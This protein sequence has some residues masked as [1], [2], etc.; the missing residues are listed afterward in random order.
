[1]TYHR[2]FRARP[3]RALA[4][5]SA[6][7][8]IVATSVAA[9]PPASA[10]STPNACRSVVGTVNACLRF[11]DRGFGWWDAQVG[12]D[13]YMPAQYGREILACGADFRASLWGDDGGN[14]QLISNLVIKPGWPQPADAGGISAE[15]TVPVFS[16]QLDEDDGQDELYARISFSDCH[17]GWTR[18]FVTGTIR[19][20]F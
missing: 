20:Y 12:I 16:S 3:P 15:F 10:A 5:L 13:V 11:D 14:D 6:A 2:I 1:M 19:G 9:A 18:R 17:T 7:L 8:A 4:A